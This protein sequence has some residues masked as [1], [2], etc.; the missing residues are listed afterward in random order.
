MIDK[1]LSVGTT[2]DWIT[3]LWTLIQDWRNRPSVG[4]SVP[5]DGG[6]SLYA[7]KGALTGKGVKTWGWMIVDGVILFRTRQAQAQYAQ[8]WLE[9]DGVPYSGGITKRTR[10][11]RRQHARQRQQGS[12]LGTLAKWCSK[13]E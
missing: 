8:Y 12:V 6:S 3:P 1:A 11:E 7:I 13:G 10:P 9:R 4:Y 5:V 2:F